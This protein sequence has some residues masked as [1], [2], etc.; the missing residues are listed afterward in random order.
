MVSIVQTHSFSDAFTAFGIIESINRYYPNI[1]DWYVNTAM[2][3]I[4]T[5]DDILLL[6]K[7]DNHK[8]VGV[9]LAKTG[10]E[11]KLRCVRVIPE[12]AGSGLGIKLIDSALNLIGDKPLVS[13]S[14]ELFHD[15]SRMFVTR[16][17]FNLTD[18][19]KGAYRKGKLEYFFN[20]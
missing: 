18:V 1:M 19:V 10:K 3:S 16:Y 7:D 8:T 20:Q 6:A 4:V 15:Y 13:V 14:E 9:A 17:G 11:N 5:G 2:P 12:Y